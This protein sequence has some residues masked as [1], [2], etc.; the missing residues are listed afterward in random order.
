[1]LHCG[2][3]ANPRY[4][5]RDEVF[6]R[7][8]GH[9]LCP[10]G[11]TDVTN[12]WEHFRED[13]PDFA[14]GRLD[15]R[16]AAE[17]EQ[18]ART[19]ASLRRAIEQERQLDAW[20]E[21]LEVPDPE[22]GM[23]ERFWRRFQAE[24]VHGTRRW[25]W[26][27]AGALAAGLVLATAALLVVSHDPRPSDPTDA[28]ARDGVAEPAAQDAQDMEDAVLFE[29]NELDYLTEGSV[30]R[31]MTQRRLDADTL[32]LLKLLDNDEAFGGLDDIRHG[33][34][35]LLGADLALLRALADADARG[36]LDTTE[37]EDEE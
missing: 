7:T 11:K 1:M 32:R 20:L 13:L 37:Q 26:R 36:L 18:A 3:C 24:K 21:H 4:L 16:R 25:L 8:W 34:E 19:D 28:T 2:I 5:G 31:W 27:A 12:G 33:E 10:N 17:I 9:R 29:W 35:V 30:P 15:A 23:E 14:R 6:D 22:P